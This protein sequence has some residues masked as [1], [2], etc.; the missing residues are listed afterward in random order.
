M[1]ALG[2]LSTDTAIVTNQVCFDRSEFRKRQP[3]DFAAFE[4]APL[5]LS[6]LG[7]KSGLPL[8]PFNPVPLGSGVSPL[9]LSVF[10]VA[11]ASSGGAH[12]ATRGVQKSGTP[13]GAPEGGGPLT[14]ELGGELQP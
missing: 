12:G 5:S 13:P 14:I 4:R 1:A 3:E 9:G 6:V 2:R 10:S 8:A 11:T 7:A